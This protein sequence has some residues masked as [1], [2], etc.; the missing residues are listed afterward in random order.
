M[1][2][3]EKTMR[4]LLAVDLGRL[5]PDHI[6]IAQG[7]AVAGQIE[8]AA[9]KRRAI[10]AFALLGIGQI[11]HVVLGEIRMKHHVAET[12]LA[13]V[14]DRRYAG[15]LRLLASL[16][17][18]KKG[19]ALFSD[20]H[21]AVR[22]E[23]HR[24]GFVEIGDRRDRDGRIAAID[25]KTVLGKRGGGEKNRADEGRGDGRGDLRHE[26]PHRCMCRVATK[27]FARQT[28]RRPLPATG[29]SSLPPD[30]A[31]ARYG[32]KAERK[33]GVPSTRNHP[34]VMAMRGRMHPWGRP[35]LGPIRG[36]AD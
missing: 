29:K 26:M 8:R 4:W 10:A 22:Q 9:S 23:G 31:W 12:A 20:E 36:P 6:D 14:S 35:Q 33:A 17:D 21:G 13:T 3:G 1:P 5:A 16:R 19:A 18:M 25:G 28:D 32:K 27:P 24:P 11:D 34:G 15:D 2:S 7:R 30:D